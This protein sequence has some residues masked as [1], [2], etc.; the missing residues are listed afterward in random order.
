MTCAVVSDSGPPDPGHLLSSSSH[1]SHLSHHCIPLNSH[2]MLAFLM[3]YIH[4]ITT[5]NIG[6]MTI[7]KKNLPVYQR[8]YTYDLY[9]MK[10][11]P[12]G[13]APPVISWF[14]NHYNPH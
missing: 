3:I 13:W 2:K 14:I 10:Y 6:A 12:T 4:V 7:A 8:Y 5:K 11:L 9:P 1:L